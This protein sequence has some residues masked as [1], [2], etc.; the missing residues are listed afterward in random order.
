MMDKAQV[1]DAVRKNITAIPGIIAFQY[2]DEEFK[3]KLIAVEREAES[4]GACG[5]LMPFTN[6]G[7]WKTSS[8]CSSS[9]SSGKPREDSS[10]PMRSGS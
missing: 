7:V 3:E 6:E 9:T 4:H 10:S 5:G 1:L 8:A 2:L